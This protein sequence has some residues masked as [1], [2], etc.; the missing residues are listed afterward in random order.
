MILFGADRTDDPNL[1][2]TNFTK[3][4]QRTEK[5]THTAQG[6]KRKPKENEKNYTQTAT[7]THMTR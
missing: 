6:V 4:S 5:N 7:H 1:P 3:A 2:V